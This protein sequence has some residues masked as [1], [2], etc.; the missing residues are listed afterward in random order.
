MWQNREQFCLYF[1]AWA[2]FSTVQLQS[3]DCCCLMHVWS[4]QIFDSQN[5]N[6]VPPIFLFCSKGRFRAQIKWL[7]YFRDAAAA[8]A[9]S[10]LG[11][12]ILLLLLLLSPRWP[13]LDRQRSREIGIEG[14]KKVGLNCI[15]MMMTKVGEFFRS[16]CF[17]IKIIDGEERGRLVLVSTT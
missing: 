6:T 9:V 4:R 16:V 12:K 10:W 2:S 11:R 5:P 13:Q 15:R 17:G 7:H 3:C 14:K 1:C 8:A